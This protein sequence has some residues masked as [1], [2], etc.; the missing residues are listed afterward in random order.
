MAANNEKAYGLFDGPSESARFFCGVCD[1]DMEVRL[2]AGELAMLDA[3]S[4]GTV[5]HETVTEQSSEGIK[6]L[7]GADP[8]QFSG[9]RHH[10]NRNSNAA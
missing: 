1:Q 2:A 5:T 6:L 7:A 9:H 10:E 4:A 8:G 3:I